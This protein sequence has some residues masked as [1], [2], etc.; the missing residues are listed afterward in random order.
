MAFRSVEATR[1]R[2]I[3]RIKRLDEKQR[4]LI[5]R[6]VYSLVSDKKR[7]ILKYRISRLSKK[8]KTEKNM[9]K[10]KRKAKHV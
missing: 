4:A 5:D 7:K 2:S 8:I 1:R 10:F 3:K 6:L 9:V